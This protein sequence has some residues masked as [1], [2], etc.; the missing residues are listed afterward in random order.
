[1]E[2]GSE[3]FSNCFISV[4]ALNFA[5]APP[6]LKYQ[7]NIFD[8]INCKVHVPTA[9]SSAISLLLSSRINGCSAVNSRR[10]ILTG[11]QPPAQCVTEAL[12]TETPDRG[13][14]GNLN[15]SVW[16]EWKP[17]INCWLTLKETGSHETLMQNPFLLVLTPADSTVEQKHLWNQILRDFFLIIKLF[18]VI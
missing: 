16:R 6:Y 3:Y 11:K 7:H 1:M 17:P 8:L 18:L 9:H 4:S 2:C 14:S 10:S 12:M 15:R 13:A 5:P